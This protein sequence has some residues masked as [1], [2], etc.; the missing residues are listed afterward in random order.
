MFFFV[1]NEGAACV[2]ASNPDNG[3]GDV[4]PFPSGDLTI[5]LLILEGGLKDW[6][7]LSEDLLKPLPDGHNHLQ[8]LGCIVM[9]QRLCH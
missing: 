8:E 9:H 7:K 5:G 4:Y 6:K 3:P 1:Q 2:P